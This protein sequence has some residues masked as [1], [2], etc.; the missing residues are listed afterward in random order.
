M[1]M[2][3][4]GTAGVYSRLTELFAW[5]MLEINLARFAKAHQKVV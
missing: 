1:Y 5:Q 4:Y 2:N 3:L